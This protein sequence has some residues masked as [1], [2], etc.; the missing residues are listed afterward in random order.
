[1][2]GKSERVIQILED[3]LRGC[4]PVQYLNGTIRGVYGRRCHTP[5][6]WI[7]LGER[8]VLGPELIFDTNDKV[9]LIRDWLKEV[10]N[11]QKSYADLKHKEIE[12]SIEY[13]VFLKV[14]PWKKILRFGR[15][16][17]LSLRFVRPYRILRQVGPV[18]HQLELPS[19]L[20]RIH[21]VFHVS[22]LRRYRSDPSHIILVEE[23]KVGLD[24][25][26]EEESV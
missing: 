9:K 14:S 6:C 2:D 4:L 7:E 19:K 11:R 25:T 1:M 13:Y 21:D 3:M 16:G 10:S 24:L 26:I 20:D 12:Y 18:A 23:I 17:K 15:K 5:T 8:R 22:M